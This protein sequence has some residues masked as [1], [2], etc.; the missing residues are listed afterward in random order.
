MQAT[1]WHNPRC[2]T[3]RKV[4]ERLEARGVE[5]HV[6]AYLKGRMTRADWEGL[7]DGV[8]GDP[9]RLLRA[10]EPLYKDLK[11]EQK[12]AAGKVGREQVLDLLTKHPQ[13]L[14]RPVVRIGGRTAI[15]RPAE[16]VDEMLPG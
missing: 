1:I 5:L 8:G 10:R 7:V 4:K 9:T 13:L 12:I 6:V 14:E 2:A 11:L 16:K 3:S 15:V